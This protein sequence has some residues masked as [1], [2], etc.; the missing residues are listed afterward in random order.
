MRKLITIRCQNNNTETQYPL[1]T[2]LFTILEDQKIKLKYDAVGA[3]VNNEVEELSYEIYKSKTVNFFDVENSDGMRMYIRS[4]FFVLLKAVKDIYPDIT[5]MV[6]HAISN[7]YFCELAREQKEISQEEIDKIRLQMQSI[8]NKNIPF[9]RKEI[10]RSE[11]IDIYEKNNAPEKARLFKQMG[12]IYTEVYEL[13]GFIDFFYG[14]L[15]P[16]TGLIKN[17]GL[18]KLRHGMLLRIPEPGDIN[19]LKPVIE[20]DKLFDVFSEH[21]RRVRILNA[22]NIGRINEHLETGNIGNLIKVAEAL[23]E[24]KIAD[25][26]AKIS[27]DSKIKLILIAGPSS[28]G[29][30][31]FSKRLQIQL[32]VAERN[33]VQISMDNYFVNREDTPKDEKGEYDF[34]TIKAL[35]LE[36]FNKNINSLIKGE[37]IE[38][39]KFS[40]ENGKRFYD[41]EKLKI[42]DKTIIIVEGIHALNPELTKQIEK[43]LKYQIYISALTQIGIDGH[44]RI[45]TTDNRLLRRMIRDA[46]FRGYSAQETIKRWDSV[47]SGE[48]KNIFPYQENC[49]IMFNSALIY[50]LAVLKKHAEPLLREIPETCIEHAESLRLLNFL[51]YFKEIPEKEIPPTSILREFISDSSFSY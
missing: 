48:R 42:S 3:Y 19:S 15:I 27:S 5:V 8:V 51:S 4:L 37:E 6:E 26:A 50:E 46:K 28:S 14:Y 39:P 45:P 31:T 23:H 38:M 1:G 2:S 43:E 49:D 21:K 30:T 7:G 10:L 9:V 32:M 44:N 36:L 29:K 22:N 20:Q 41:G 17:F 40:F 24:K 12:S 11:A 16:S 33:T 13:D 18:Q 25:I 35:D 47:R 34:E